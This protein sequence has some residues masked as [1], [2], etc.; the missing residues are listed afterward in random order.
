NLSKNFLAQNL[1]SSAFIQVKD[2]P[3]I[4]HVK[5]VVLRKSCLLN[6]GSDKFAQLS[7]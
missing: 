1:F 5:R 6:F 3:L 7:E 4:R 2:G